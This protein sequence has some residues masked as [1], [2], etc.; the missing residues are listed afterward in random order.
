MAACSRCLAAGVNLTLRPETT[1]V[2]SKAGMLAADGRCKTLDAAADGYMRGEACVVHVLD[3]RL[4]SACWSFSAIV[5]TTVNQ[6]GRSSSLTAPHGPS[7]QALLREALALSNAAAP[8]IVVLELHGTGTLLGDPIE[9]G[10]ATTVLKV[11][12]AA[13]VHCDIQ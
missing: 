13:R 6:D 5:G 11:S 1:A 12:Q 9:V 4:P 2:L 7:Q 10:A 8:D 3:T